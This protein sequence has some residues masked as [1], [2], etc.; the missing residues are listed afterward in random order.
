MSSQDENDKYQ[1]EDDPN[2]TAKHKID[3]L[4][5]FKQFKNSD[6][7]SKKIMTKVPSFEPASG[8][9]FGVKEQKLIKD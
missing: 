8:I 4:D 2:D 6:K 9:N 7:T 3:Q 1:I 5:E